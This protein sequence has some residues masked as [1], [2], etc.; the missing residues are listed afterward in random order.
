MR[1]DVGFAGIVVAG[2]QKEARR[3]DAA[4]GDGAARV[5]Q[6]GLAA[7]RLDALRK[8][9]GICGDADVFEKNTI[10]VAVVDEE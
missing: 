10:L 3:L 1:G 8:R 9:T 7:H 6:D 2:D 4:G 5:G